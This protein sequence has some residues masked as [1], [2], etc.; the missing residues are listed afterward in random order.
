[1]HVCA[2][3]GTTHPKCEIRHGAKFRAHTQH[4]WPSESDR[5]KIKIN[6]CVEYKSQPFF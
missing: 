1:M 4:T 2:Q 6:A 5:V 3:K